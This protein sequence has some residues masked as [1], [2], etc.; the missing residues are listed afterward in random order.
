MQYNKLDLPTVEFKQIDNSTDS[1]GCRK[2]K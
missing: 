1:V 2:C